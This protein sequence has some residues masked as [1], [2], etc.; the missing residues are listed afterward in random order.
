MAHVRRRRA[1]LAGLLG[2]LC[3]A[4]AHAAETVSPHELLDRLNEAVRQLDYEGRFVVQ[5]GDRLDALYI[6]HRASTGSEN[7]RVVTLNGA[8]RE[9]IRSGQAVC[10]VSDR[11]KRVN[12]GRRA[13][14]RSFSP[15]RGVSA[16]QLRASY[17]MR[18]LEPG[19]V[20]GRAAH[21]I[22]VA[23]RDDL[24]FGYRLFLDQEWALPLRSVMIDADGRSIS[25][26]MFVDLQVNEGITPIEQD[27]AIMQI[28]A[29]EPEP[30][31]LLSAERL[32]PP[33]WEFAE[34][35]PGFHMNAHRRRPLA[36]G[37][38]EREHFIFSDGLASVSVYVQPAPAGR[39][40]AGVSQLGSARAVGRAFEGHE[41]IVVGEVP[42]KT[43][44]WFAE[45]IRAAER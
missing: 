32:A 15:L 29:A 8:P 14:D 44:H 1:R 16:D 42:L 43:L 12:V 2:L 20:A 41:V 6:V 31:P 36:G 30:E 19:R 37:N 24:R 4:G 5:A 28:A 35:P 13:N 10:L 9:I 26:M 33:A 22:L 27:E 34:L 17:D 40:L 23:P 45:S 39:E 18:M 21:Q 3:A 7:E 11:D 25:Q 38:G